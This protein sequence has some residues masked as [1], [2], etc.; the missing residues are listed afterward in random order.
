M[1]L[2]TN[3]TKV[4]IM[5]SHYRISGHIS[6]LHEARVTDYICESKNFIAVTDAEI[7]SHDQRRVASTS[8]LN[9]NREHIELIMPDDCVTQ[10]GGMHIS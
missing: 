4:I 2:D 3:K 7:W 1:K 10:S 5:T 6:V 9:I 8:F